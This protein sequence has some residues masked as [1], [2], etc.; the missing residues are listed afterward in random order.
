MLFKLS[1]PSAPPLFV[2][3][4]FSVAGLGRLTA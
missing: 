1:T 2:T 4:M 3:V